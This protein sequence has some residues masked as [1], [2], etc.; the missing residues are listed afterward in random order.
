M[1]LVGVNALHLRRHARCFPVGEGVIKDIRNQSKTF[2][3][4]NEINLTH[5][6]VGTYGDIKD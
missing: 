1:T 6:K 2:I 4:R 3:L 5:T